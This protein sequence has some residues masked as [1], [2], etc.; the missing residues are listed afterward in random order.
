[1]HDWNLEARE[2]SAGHFSVSLQRSTGEK[3]ERD[4]LEDVISS[5]LLD[6][7]RLDRKLGVLPGDSAFLL[8]RAAKRSW[9]WQ[10]F[11]QALGSWSGV[12]KVGA[13][14][15]DYDGKD[16]ILMLRTADSLN[17]KIPWQGR[18]QSLESPEGKKYFDA[19]LYAY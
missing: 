11:D 10:F 18:V 7:F 14:R 12:S 5:A 15:V 19:L 6:G 3:I 1:M 9:R 16:F 17:P 2:L 8:T 4:G 13:W